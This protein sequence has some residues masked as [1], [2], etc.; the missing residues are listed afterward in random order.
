MPIA[1][2]TMLQIEGANYVQNLPFPR[3]YKVIR[4]KSCPA[5]AEFVVEVS[6]ARSAMVE[7]SNPEYLLHKGGS[8]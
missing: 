6:R 8:T 5:P 2:D 3:G 1:Y 7:I 4:V